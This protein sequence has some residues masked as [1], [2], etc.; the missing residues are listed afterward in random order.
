[1]VKMSIL[2]YGDPISCDKSFGKL[3]CR[4][5]MKERVLILEEMKKSKE[6]GKKCLTL[7][8]NCMD[9]AVID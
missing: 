2:W 1:M 4:L 6:S 8:K 7:H 5:Y 3:N 9:L